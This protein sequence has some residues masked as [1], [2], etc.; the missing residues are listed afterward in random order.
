MDWNDVAETYANLGWVWEGEGR[1]SAPVTVIADSA[2]H[3]SEV[4]RVGKVM[5]KPFRIIVDG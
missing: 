1:A 4:R 2:R 5:H 3:S